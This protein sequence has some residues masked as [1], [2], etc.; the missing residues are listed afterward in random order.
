MNGISWLRLWP[1]LGLVLLLEAALLAA[2]GGHWGWTAEGALLWA[3]YT[4]RLSFL[5]FLPP[6]LASALAYWLKSNPARQMLKHRRSLGLGFALAHFVHLAALVSYFRLSGET[7]DQSAVIGGGIGYIFVALMA[8]TS[9]DHSVRI[10]GRGWP[11][12]HKTGAYYIWFIFAFTYM[13]RLIEPDPQE[14]YGLYLALFGLVVAAL[15]LRLWR[16]LSRRRQ[17][18]QRAG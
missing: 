6:F 16:G 2:V 12:L 9:N 4:A 8:L 1:Y 18:H 3:R 11:L 15:L 7:P 5:L 13:G 14:P 17:R 10:L